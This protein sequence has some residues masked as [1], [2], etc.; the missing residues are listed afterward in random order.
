MSQQARAETWPEIKLTELN[1]NQFKSSQISVTNDPVFHAAK[2][3]IAFPLSDLLDMLKKPDS[4]AYE[5]ILIVFTAKD[6]YKVTMRFQ[7]ASIS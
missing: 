7:D 5:N 4:V 2:K 6:G 3:Y 1:L